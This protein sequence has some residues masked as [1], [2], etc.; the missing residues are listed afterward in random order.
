[1][2][3]ITNINS[4]NS[5]PKWIQ[6]IREIKDTPIILVGNKSDLNRERVVS[7][8]QGKELKENL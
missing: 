4:F 3:D 1:M 7:K 5:V 6:I 2:Y 8:E